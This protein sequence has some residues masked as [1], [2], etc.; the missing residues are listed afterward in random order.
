[1]D[2]TRRDLFDTV[3][4]EGGSLPAYPGLQA[5][6]YVAL[7]ARHLTG[8]MI[9]ALIPAARSPNHGFVGHAE[10]QIVR[11]AGSTWNVISIAANR[12]ICADVCQPEIVE[13]EAQQGFKIFTSALE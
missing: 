2:P 1:M 5:V 7:N 9:D 10:Q 13:K 6:G 4:I 11:F 12:P 3:L 8:R